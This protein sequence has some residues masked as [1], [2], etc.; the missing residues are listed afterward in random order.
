MSEL[1]A[2]IVSITN[3]SEDDALFALNDNNFE[4]TLA[5]DELMKQLPVRKSF[6]ASHNHY[7][8]DV[9]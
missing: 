1:V 5:L 2:Q 3:V 9:V 6:F 4:L 7:F 8:N